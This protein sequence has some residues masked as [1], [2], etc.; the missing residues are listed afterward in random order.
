MPRDRMVSCSHS[1]AASPGWHR[2]TIIATAATNDPARRRAGSSAV[3]PLRQLFGVLQVLLVLGGLALSLQCRLAQVGPQLRA[4]EVHEL[5]HRLLEGCEALLRRV[6][7]L[8]I[9]LPDDADTVAQLVLDDV[10]LLQFLAFL[11]FLDVLFLD[12]LG[13]LV[14]ADLLADLFFLDELLALLLLRFLDGF[15][16]D[17]L[18][19]F[20][21]HFLG[22][23]LALAE[24]AGCKGPEIGTV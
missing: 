16:D 18:A 2:M 24:R 22:E 13:V 19:R 5:A 17:F 9:G 14:L 10:L 6:S 7:A 23:L 3:S 11:E 15:L 4:D 1:A 8:C 21:H 20:L 12:L